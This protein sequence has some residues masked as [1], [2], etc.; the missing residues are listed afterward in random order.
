M[1][2]R[3]KGFTLIE[4]MIVIAIIG[5][6]ASIA[7][8]LYANHSKRAKF[9]EIISASAPVRTAI[10]SCLSVNLSNERCDTWAEIGIVKEQL[11]QTNLLVDVS[12]ESGTGAVTFTAHPVQ[13]NGA[14]YIITPTYDNE[15]SLM[16]WEDSGTCK[17]DSST[18]Y[19]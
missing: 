8:P 11:L 1:K 12:M 6:L 7:V 2:T 17:T 18:R 13:L 5:I 14:T 19:C 4:L 3:K 16:I 9:A 10:E 15:S